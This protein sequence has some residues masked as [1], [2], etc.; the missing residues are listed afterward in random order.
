MPTIG[1]ML[2]TALSKK[3]ILKFSKLE[4][5]H[6]SALIKH[7]ECSCSLRGSLFIAQQNRFTEEEVG[8]I[9]LQVDHL[10]SLLYI[11]RKND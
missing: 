11:L 9:Y 8:D 4:R 5:E 3:K 6:L 1:T 2:S 10:K 7:L